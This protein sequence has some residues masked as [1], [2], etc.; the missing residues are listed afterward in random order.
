MKNRFWLFKRGT[1]YYIQ[2]SL[3]GK[4]ESLHTTNVN[5][6]KRL[7]LAKNE[8]A[9]NPTLGLAL[10]RAYL[11]AHDPKI[12]KR[13]WEDVM[14]ELSTHGKEVSQIRCRREMNSKPFHLIRRKPLVETTAQDL[15]EVIRSGTVS[16][17]H[18]LRRLH[19]LALGMGWLPWPILA[20]KLWPRI[21]TKPKRAIT[22]EEHKRIVSTE[23]N[24]ERRLYY[25]LLWE[26]GA[27]QTDAV[28]LSN[29]NINWASRT[30]AYR[31]HKTGQ[32]ACLRIGVNL[33]RILRQLPNQ[34]ML[35][36]Y[37]RQF[38]D[39]D[40]AREFRRRCQILGIQGVTLHSYRYSWAERAKSS[41]YPSR[42]AQSALGHNSR[43]VH[44]AYAKE[45]LVVC[46]PLEEY[47]GKIVHLETA[48]H[49]LEHKAI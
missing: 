33:E 10:G 40:R 25:E 42:W 21:V 24:V 29:E 1:A 4:Q 36:P 47:E 41:G 31:R 6:A 2:D 22:T 12:G 23:G 16:T 32:L 26:T 20:P 18:Y 7:R 27:S 9:E 46:P 37:W 3:T 39:S 14:T 35:F 49:Q 43:A 8:G 34:G 17:N 19:N 13:V 44:E 15:L 5:E 28:D 45:A 48:R 30:L 11:S 38:R